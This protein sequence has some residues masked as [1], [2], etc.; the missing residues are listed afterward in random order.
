[1]QQQR[2]DR[3][4]IDQ[5]IASGT[6]GTVYRARD[7]ITE[8][9]VA[10]K[11][12]HPHWAP[13]TSLVE[14]F[15]RE[16]RI[17]QSV[18]HPNIV[19]I[20]AVGQDGDQHF[21]AME[22]L[23]VSVHD[24]MEQ[25]PRM[26]VEY[27]IDLCVQVAS[28]LNAA[29]R[30]GITHRDI[31]PQNLLISEDG[32]VKLA[33]FGIARDENLS[34]MT[35]TGAQMGTPAYMSPEQIR[36]GDVD[37][38]SDIY[39]LGVVLYQMLAGRPPFESESQLELAR[40]HIEEQPVSVSRLR[41][42][43]SIQLAQVVMKCLSKDPLDRYQTPYELAEALR[44]ARNEHRG[45]PASSVP[46]FA[47]TLPVSYL[48]TTQAAEPSL[49]RP[50]T[51]RTGASDDR[52][53]ASGA[54]STRRAERPPK[55]PS[56]GVR[57]PVAHRDIGAARGKRQFQRVISL[58]VAAF[59]VL[60]LI[61]WGATSILGG[62]PGQPQK[63]RLAATALPALLAGP[64]P[65]S[66]VPPALP[67]TPL[68]STDQQPQTLAI[69][70]GVPGVVS[71][72]GN[73]PTPSPTPMPDTG[74]QPP[75]TIPAPM[76]SPTSGVTTLATPTPMA[77]ADP[78]TIDLLADLIVV[79]E[80]FRWE[81]SSPSVGDPV[82][83]LITVVN[84]GGGDAVASTLAYAVDG[85]SNSDWVVDVPAVP[86]GR[87]STVEFEW[88]AQPGTFNFSLMADSTDF[89]N[90]TAER[91]NDENG[92]AFSGTLL[93]DLVV[94]EMTW[95]PTSP[96]MGEVVTFSGIVRNRGEGRADAS[97]VHFYF[98]DE[99][100]AER[101]LD[102]YSRVNRNRWISL[103][104]PRSVPNRLSPSRTFTL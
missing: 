103:G 30:R 71:N 72:V 88:L 95:H 64:P 102:P 87:S 76:G 50:V 74:G 52:Q 93:A 60:A 6:Y 42:E 33:D 73:T 41:P 58:S 92:L 98:N 90:E 70:S 12:L 29:R 32:I 57:T 69:R 13:N 23:P 18:I 84:Q 63:P 77:K 34:T 53:P 81:P 80:S 82:K 49:P 89:V 5:A 31:K 9:D 14:R 86:A 45:T 75:S 83:F 22:Y 59:V 24:V 4:I 96:P 79:R 54:R 35:G 1:M 7:A 44:N 65:S 38:R 25:R 66:P 16:G 51:P 40:Q 8:Q 15:S 26:H 67:A 39:S 94:E 19:R 46:G 27:A 3:Y 104:T 101:E 61:G 28:G 56:G 91:N 100:V 17:T 47:P 20:H 78:Q 48:V 55:P 99:M 10:L 43:V 11:V 37:T 62:T 36:G 2:I 68:P 97:M 85:A 21:I